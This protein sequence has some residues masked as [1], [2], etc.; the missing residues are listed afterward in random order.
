M[1]YH[2][3]LDPGAAGADASPVV[4]DVVETAGG[5]LE[6]RV[7]GRPVSA[8]LVGLRGEASV[9]AD[10]RMFEVTIDGAL[11]NVQARAGG[12]RW[13]ARVEDERGPWAER[14]ASGRPGAAHTDAVVRSPMPGRVV[15]VLVQPGDAVEAG[16]GVVVLEAMKMENEVRAPASGVVAQVHVAA[17]A[18]V[19]AGV[20][21]VTF[22]RDESARGG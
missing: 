8:D 5:R 14:A 22:A 18:A 15:R 17:G 1:R 19:E 7:A 9:R 6:A 3:V 21:L 4:V 20:P 10:G 11:P 13:A 12:R 2:V 16:R